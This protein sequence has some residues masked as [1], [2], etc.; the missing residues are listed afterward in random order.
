M[1]SLTFP[2]RLRKENKLGPYAMFQ[3]LVHEWGSDRIKEPGDQNPSLE[4]AEIAAK[5]K[6]F[7]NF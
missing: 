1:T 7:T 4:P 6:K 3:R 5:V 2:G